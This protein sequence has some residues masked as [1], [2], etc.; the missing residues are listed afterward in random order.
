VAAELYEPTLVIEAEADAEAEAKAKEEYGAA[1][2]Y[3]AL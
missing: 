3:R 2:S 1:V